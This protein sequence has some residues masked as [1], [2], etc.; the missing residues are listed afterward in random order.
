[1]VLVEKQGFFEECKDKVDQQQQARSQVDHMFLI[2]T[3][4]K[5]S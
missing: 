2:V 1:M 3:Q 4:F 5:S